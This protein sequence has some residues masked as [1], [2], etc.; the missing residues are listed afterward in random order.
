MALDNQKIEFHRGEDF[1]PI[2]TLY[3][4]KAHE[5]E[6]ITDCTV[7]WNL[8]ADSSCGSLLKT[9][10]T[11][12]GSI[13]ITDGAGGTITFTIASADTIDLDVGTYYHECWLTKDD[14]NIQE[15][16]GPLILKPGKPP[17]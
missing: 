2:A 12:D 11:E 9:K 14:E 4:N 3:K 8:Y 6:I 15:F 16:T 7:V 5:P 1:T 13:T 10:T 17:E